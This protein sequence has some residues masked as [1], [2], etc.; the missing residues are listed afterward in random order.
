MKGFARVPR[1]RFTL[2]TL[3]LAI[4]F[5]AA[6]S[7]ILISLDREQ[8]SPQ[9]GLFLVVSSAGV[10]ALARIV[11]GIRRDR[12]SRRSRSLVRMAALFVG[13]IALTATI[14]LISDLTFLI[15]HRFFRQLTPRGTHRPWPVISDL[16]LFAGIATAML[17]AYRLRMA[18]WSPLEESRANQPLRWIQLW[19]I[20]IVA[21]LAASMG[22]E[23][24]WDRYSEGR[25]MIEY[26]AAREQYETNPKS[27]AQHQ[28]LR[29]GYERNIWRPWL[30]LHPE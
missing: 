30:P 18:F 20:G 8:P 22:Y 10:M 5:A 26:H 7:A 2:R 6:F 24:M 4:G 13:S 3:I 9:F 29:L 16:G 25:R 11:E 27:A 14:V 28:R 23:A 17:V 1:P 12:A 21:I 15:V 19:P